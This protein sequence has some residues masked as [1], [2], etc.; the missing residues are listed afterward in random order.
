MRDY[1]NAQIYEIRKGNHIFSSRF[2]FR[3]AKDYFFIE[4]EVFTAL[5]AVIWT[6]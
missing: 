6:K 5:I 1:M 2:Q 3:E 4:Y